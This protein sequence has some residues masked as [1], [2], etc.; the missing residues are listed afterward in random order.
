MKKSAYENN[1][2]I[3]EKVLDLDKPLTIAEVCVQLNCTGI[4]EL[5]E[6]IYNKYKAADCLNR[7]YTHPQY[8]MAAVYAACK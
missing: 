6:D 1:L 4:K 8:V 2:H 7:D 3:V 5:A